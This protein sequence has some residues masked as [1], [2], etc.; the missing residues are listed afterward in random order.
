MVDV[1]SDLP[2]SNSGSPKHFINF[3][4]VYC[5]GG[6]GT[7]LRL[8][9][10]LFMRC[11][12]PVLPQIVTFSMGSMSYLCYFDMS[13]YAKILDHTI[14]APIKSVEAMIKVDYR[15]RLQCKLENIENQQ[16]VNWKRLFINSE[17][18]KEVQPA[19]CHALNEIS[20]TRGDAEF[21]ARFDIFVND[22][23]LTT[24]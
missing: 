21:M 13:E 14:L 3:Q 10:I 24:V 22:V 16:P 1:G 6:D 8:L 19:I 4:F 12:P 17:G 5:I 7:L 20:I 23:P 11:L 18:S 9:R 2:I 15:A